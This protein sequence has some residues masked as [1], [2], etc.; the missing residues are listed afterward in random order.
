MLIS[1]A[2]A[3]GFIEIG[4]DWHVFKLLR[5]YNDFRAIFTFC[6]K[7]QFYL[8]SLQPLHKKLMGLIIAQSFNEISRWKKFEKLS[9]MLMESKR[10]RFSFVLF[11]SVVK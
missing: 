8:F 4:S 6:N 7:K 1:S 2:Y 11:I 10:L 3:T 5:L 9:A